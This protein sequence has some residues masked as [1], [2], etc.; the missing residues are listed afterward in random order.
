MHNL[1]CNISFTITH[2][3][4]Q[5]T[6][7]SATLLVKLPFFKASEVKLHLDLKKRNG[8][9]KLASYLAQHG[10]IVYRNVVQYQILMF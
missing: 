6:L 3:Q 5:R 1:G 10:C 2:S 4:I 7:A 9:D 8:F